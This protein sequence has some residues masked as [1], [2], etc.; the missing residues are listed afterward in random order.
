MRLLIPS[1]L[2][3]IA[4]FC[5]SAPAQ[6]MPQTVAAHTPDSALIYALLQTHMPTRHGDVPHL[7]PEEQ[8]G[9]IVGPKIKLDPV[10]LQREGRELLE[11]SQSLQLD[12]DSVN[13]GVLP[14]DTIGKLK[15]I[16]KLSKHLRG[17]IA[18]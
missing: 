8:I 3:L 12:I 10:Q 15:R 9:P 4:A 7:Q 6:L 18:P 11:L 5:G 2:V 16:E 13:H 17:E 14:K 1:S